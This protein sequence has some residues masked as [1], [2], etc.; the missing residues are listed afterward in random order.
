MAVDDEEVMVEEEPKPGDLVCNGCL[1][2]WS[3]CDCDDDHGF[4]RMEEDEDTP[5]VSASAPGFTWQ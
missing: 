5:A 3:L 1:G 2:F 4:I